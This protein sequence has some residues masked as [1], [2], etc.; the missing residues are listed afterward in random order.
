MMSK[1]YIYLGTALIGIGILSSSIVTPAMAKPMLKTSHQ[2][3]PQVGLVPSNIAIILK[4][5]STN[6]DCKRVL[7]DPSG[8]ISFT[9]GNK[10]GQ[11]TLEHSL[12]MKFFKD[13]K[14]AE[15][16]SKLSVE[17]CLKSASFGTSTFVSLGS[18]K[19][20]DLSCPGDA[21]AKQLFA[22]ANAIIEALNP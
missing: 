6:A 18:E 4:T 8:H 21:N 5:A 2:C 3:Q 1:F 16:L 9:I 13:I 22:D 10:I 7:V 15:P 17:R 11:A 14:I 19:S 20:P 12:V